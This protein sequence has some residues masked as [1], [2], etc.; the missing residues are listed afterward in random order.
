M[1]GCSELAFQK[2]CDGLTYEHL[3]I[4]R[5]VHLATCNCYKTTKVYLARVEQSAEE[6]DGCRVYSPNHLT[7]V[8]G[9]DVVDLNAYVT[10]RTRT[11]E[12]VHL[13]VLG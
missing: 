7:L 12:Y 3:C 11:V 13:N 5:I 9:S 2:T 10:S 6:D 4:S 1:L 8:N